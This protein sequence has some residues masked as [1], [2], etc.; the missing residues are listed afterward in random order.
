[1]NFKGTAGDDDLVG[2]TGNDLFN[3]TQGGEDIVKAGAG[4]DTIQMGATLDAGDQINGQGGNDT[5]TI[6]GDYSAGLVLGANTL[7][8]VE[9]LVLGAG[10]DY[11]IVTNDGNVALNRVLQVN[12]GTLGSSDSVFFD[13]SAETDGRFSVT[14]GN[15]VD[16]VLGG[17]GNDFIKTNGGTDTIDPGI[18]N[19]TVHAGDGDDTIEFSQTGAFN[20]QDR[21]DGGAGNDTV[22]I[23]EHANVV[24]QYSTM[25][26]V[27]NIQL[28]GDFSYGLT[29]TNPVVAAGQTLTVDASGLA[30]AADV[31]NF[32]GHGETD[33]SFDITGGP[34]NDQIT[35]GAQGDT[36]EGGDGN[37]VITP[38]GGA[39]TVSGG[40]GDDTI[41]MGASLGAGDFVDGGNGADKLVL[42]GD[43]SAGLDFST[44]DVTGVETIQLKAG[45]S[46]DLDLGTGIGS[47][48]FTINAKPLGAADTLT[49]DAS[50][51][52]SG[53]FSVIGGAGDDSIALGSGE[54]AASHIDGGAGNDTVSLSGDYTAGL[55]FGAGTMINVETLD[56]LFSPGYDIVTSDATVAAGA[57][58][59][60]DAS[61]VTNLSSAFTFDG[62]AE[63]DGSFVVVG[64]AANNDITTGAGDDVIDL[65]LSTHGFAS[66][67]HAGAGDDQITLIGNFSAQSVIDGGAGNDIV[68]IAGNFNLDLNP[69]TL[70]SVE[71]LD[72]GGGYNYVLAT[73]DANV[74]AGQTMTVDASQLGAANTLS[75][76]GRAETDGTIDVTGGAGADT[77]SLTD[78]FS[79]TSHIDGGGGND[80]LNVYGDYSAGFVFSATTLTNILSLTLDG[81]YSYN[82]TTN[83]ATV[84]AGQQ[85][86]V[87]LGPAAG[88]LTFD[89]SAET[90]GSLS[91]Q[92]GAGNDVITGGAQDDIIDS[93]SGGTDTL[94]GGGGNDTFYLGATL[95]AFDHIDGGTGNDTIQLNGDYS[96]GVDFGATT[97][98]NVE[99]IELTGGHS[100]VL[101]TAD[102]N[103][104]AG[105]TLAVDAGSLGASDSLNFDGSLETDGSFRLSGGAG[106]DALDG[107]A[108]ADQISI[109]AGGNDVVF[110]G[111]GDDAIYGGGAF[112]A[113][114][115]INGGT[116]N[117]TLTLY[118]DYSAGVTFN[119]FTLQSVEKIVVQGSTGVDYSFTTADGNVASGAS[120][121][122]DA[123]SLLSTET[124]TFNGSAETDGGFYIVSGAGT[125]NATGG[126]KTDIFDMTDAT[127]AHISG[128]GGNDIVEFGNF[129]AGDSVD[130]GAG[131][132]AVLISSILNMTFGATT[133]TNVEFLYLDA[134]AGQYSITTND[135]NVA[136]GATLT[137][138]ATAGG[139]GGGLTF[140]GSAETD[141][142]FSIKGTAASDTITTGKGADTIYGG[143]GG[144][145]LSGGSGADTFVYDAV[146]ESTGYGR[147]TIT[148]FIASADK[149]DLNVS[150]T[151]IDAKVTAGTL[152]DDLG[153]FDTNLAAAIGS[154]KLAAHH[155]VL[156]A[157]SAGTGQGETFLIVDAN[158]VAGYQAGADYVMQI[159]D[160]GIIGTL[161]TANFI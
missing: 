92:G 96:G 13:G 101:T 16:T 108:Q 5:V 26:D 2:T 45:H 70:T 106:N 112:T 58:M 54:T 10:F 137:V 100:Y 88:T 159:N 138:D 125:C 9:K 151:G 82:L 128:G 51:A 62:S 117:D 119:N 8:G 68:R 142:S 126:A 75:L 55:H 12:A 61:G 130:G 97:I 122:I 1:M 60:V 43:Y 149:F 161:T 18:G 52:N 80:Q 116:G 144:D 74:A 139:V 4:D 105:Q 79:A 156:F 38:G 134:T 27:E 78:A 76:D 53:N 111:G 39:D 132:D 67:V 31:L 73:D 22:V 21:I 14:T 29:T 141:G 48:A 157:P 20:A 57:T 104:G 28:D 71:T 146:S 59:R 25:V 154:S 3:M 91:I 145:L 19:D 94:S 150:V 140:N 47:G 34:G 41:N 148:D 87:T 56:L 37:D 113:A 90:D 86:Y 158:G 11:D 127:A 98:V 109:S 135:A 32:N 115:Q 42:N 153:N 121:E 131:N 99:K 72:L 114:D 124:L 66:A 95:D 35:G 23:D 102:A 143:G 65:S 118:G 6:L 110:A 63:T 44:L 24:F 77:I 129:T 136:S 15:G 93:G 89:A 133:L 17:A 36:I 7:I 33:G 152:N 50:Y 160:P 46:Y 85:M 107:G 83:D 30:S 84:A 40:D 64:C 147:D 120:L 123:S 49:L 69:A 81:P 155:A 103:V